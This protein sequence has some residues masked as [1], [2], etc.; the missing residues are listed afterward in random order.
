M[1]LT[2][3]NKALIL[4]LLSAP[5]LNL[6][7]QVD[8]RLI[9]E[10]KIESKILKETR[11]ILISK[12]TGYDYS[13]DSYFVVYVLDGNINTAFTTGI[14]ELLY[15]SG[16]PKLLV[17]GIPNTNRARDLTPSS[18]NHDAISG[19]SADNFLSFLE[20]ELIPYVDGN[21][22]THDYRALIGHSWGGLFVSHAFSQN[23]KVFNGYIAITPTIVHND[24]KHAQALKDRLRAD[25][26]L[27]NSFFF[28][29]GHEPGEEG[30]GVF[31]MRD[32]FEENAPR[33][34]KWDFAYYRKENHSTTPLIA[35]IDGLRFIFSDLVLDDNLVKEKG[36]QFV[37][38]YYAS[39]EK[40]YGIPIKIP[41]RVMMTY[42][43]ELMNLKRY[44]L[45]IEVFNHFEKIYP[46][47]LVSYDALA[48]I[49]EDQ[50]KKKEAIKYLEKLLE[51]APW[52]EDAKIRLDNLRKK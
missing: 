24:F 11:P 29:V 10:V 12:P 44:D 34:L 46:K 26:S 13:E 14:C 37:K 9:E 19:G 32:W 38:D 20:T 15:Q 28:S 31:E 6:N 7:A 1:K 4:M 30:D 18:D 39:L 42:G 21:Y 17:V 40:K 50:G 48:V 52:Y 36:F 3:F 45:A 5:I 51:V 41:Q 25:K 22:R 27:N 49:Y 43:Y 33:S 35:T 2:I 23:P 16:Y 8:R 47:I